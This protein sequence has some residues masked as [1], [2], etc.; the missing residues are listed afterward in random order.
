MEIQT[1]KRKK[2]VKTI[3]I[4]FSILFALYLSVSIYFNNHFYFG[5][6]ING[7]NASGKTV[8]QVDKDLSSK[9]ATYTL[10]LKERGGVNEQI[11]ATDIRLKY[12]SNGKIQMLKDNKN[13]FGWFYEI[14][15]KKNYEISGL[16]TYD[17]K[18]LKTHFDKLSAFDSNKIIEPQNANFKYSANSYV[19]VKEVMGN[20]IKSKQLYADIVSAISKGE[21]KVDLETKN[22]YITPKYTSTSKEI[23]NTKTL[24]NKYVS[25]NISYTYAGGKSVID[26][27]VINKWLKVDNNNAIIFDQDAMKTYISGLDNHYETYGKE[28][29]FTTSLGTSLK[30]SGGDYGWKVARAGEV[31]DLIVA[32]K[33]GKTIAKEPRYTEKG[34]NHDLND[35]GNTYVEL[36]LTNQHLWF[37]KNGKLIAD[38]DVVTGKPTKDRVTPPGIYK[39]KYKAK[40]ATLK[41]E[42][43]STPVSVFMPFNG[44]IGIHDATWQSKFGGQIYFTKGS[45]GCVNSPPALAQ[46]IYD[47]IDAGTPVVCYLQ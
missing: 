31:S 17:E 7:I 20:K 32:I 4:Y 36:N 35:I 29:K 25:S 47:N 37:Y 40:N 15:N 33:N 23:L 13:S 3:I 39:L 22:D 26:K 16:V 1:I 21:T 11:K 27:S 28:R 44:G 45:H 18:L 2:S 19:I 42:G 5:S 6:V 30:V 8:D 34:L 10:E 41:G 46:K 38:G 14:F 43:Y 9:Y 24:L 12:N